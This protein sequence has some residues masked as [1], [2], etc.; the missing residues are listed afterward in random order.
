MYYICMVSYCLWFNLLHT[1]IIV[2]TDITIL[3]NLSEQTFVTCL[4]FP[5]TRK[6]LLCFAIVII[7]KYILRILMHLSSL[8]SL[9]Y[10]SELNRNNYTEYF[11]H[12]CVFWFLFYFIKDKKT[13]KNVPHY[14]V[15]YSAENNQTQT[16]YIQHGF[17]H[18]SKLLH[19]T[20]DY[21]YSYCFLGSTYSL[22][23]NRCICL[24]YRLIYTTY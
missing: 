17:M 21:S 24:K 23:A 11:K 9:H 1:I 15:K 7:S 19:K 16:W 18:N 3:D 4:I 6:H 20:K 13:Y 2:D 12:R 5:M 10:V 14:N 22:S 8:F